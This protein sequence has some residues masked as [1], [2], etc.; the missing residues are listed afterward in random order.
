[1]VNNTNPNIIVF[2]ALHLT[3]P[4]TTTTIHDTNKNYSSYEVYFHLNIFKAI[5]ST[6]KNNLTLKEL[7]N[8]KSN[9]ITSLVE[10]ILIIIFEQLTV[11]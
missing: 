10:L 11:F 1:M 4:P 2:R 5:I 9:R 8:G 6:I 7:N 3:L